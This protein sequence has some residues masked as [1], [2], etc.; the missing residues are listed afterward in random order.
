MTSV[1]RLKSAKK[2]AR[3]ALSSVTEGA[4]QLRKTRELAAASSG[5]ILRRTALLNKAV[6]GGKGLNDPAVDERVGSE[7]GGT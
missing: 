3:R 4:R 2:Q 1:R 5:T 6:R 7:G